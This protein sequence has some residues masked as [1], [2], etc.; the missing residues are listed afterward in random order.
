MKISTSMVLVIALAGCF[1]QA[2]QQEP[3]SPI[4]VARVAV[5]DTG[6]VLAITGYS[7]AGDP[8]AHVDLR[9][10]TF[11]SEELDREVL[12]RELR[13]EVR[14]QVATHQSAGLRAL[15][16]P[17]FRGPGG[18]DLDALLLDP[19]VRPVLAARQITLKD[20]RPNPLLA[21]APASDGVPYSACSFPPTAQCQGNGAYTCVESWRYHD[22]DR[23]DDCFTGADQD[24]CC[25]SAANG[26]TQMAA[27]RMCGMSVANECGAEGPNG[28]A[29][30]WNAPYRTVCTT[31]IRARVVS[32]CSDAFG[33]WQVATNVLSMQHD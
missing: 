25:A 7:T 20:T 10:G 22:T 19:R 16:L 14:G 17:L 9:V 1:T 18:D 29:V 4:G 26:G 6:P 21:A 12:G 23:T 32:R 2:E 13:V 8:I 15:R 11:Y 33:D 5:D 27:V 31:S 24:V 3:A 28:C 30:C